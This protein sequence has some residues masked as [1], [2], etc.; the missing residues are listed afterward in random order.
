MTQSARK[1]GGKWVC[2]IPIEIRRWRGNASAE[3]GYTLIEL[4]VVLAVIGILLAIAVSSYLGYAGRAADNTAKAN[5][6][7]ALPAVEAYY[8]DNDTYAGM[9]I[10]TLKAAYDSGIAP[11]ISLFGA[12]TATSYC[13]ASSVSG[14]TWSVQGPGVGTASYKSNGTCS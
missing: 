3:D 9:S 14:H 1:R 2:G 11:G 13:L 10:A 4:L 6:R 5:I 7:G 12:P 8:N